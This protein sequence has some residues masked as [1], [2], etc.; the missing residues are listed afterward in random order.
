MNWL[1]SQLR[2]LAGKVVVPRL[3]ARLARFQQRLERAREV[4][5]ALWR[6]KVRRAASSGFGRDHGF[7]QVRDYADFKKAVPI[8][9]YDYYHPY[10]DRVARGD[11]GAMFPAGEP[12]LMFTL[13]SGTTDIPKLIPINPTWMDEYRRGW[14]IW[15]VRAFLDHPRL[16]YSKVTGIAGNWDMR[17][18]PSDKPCGM[19]SGLSAKMQPGLLQMMY[20]VPPE[21]F[22]IP[23]STAKYYTALRLAVAE[24]EVGL[25]LTATPATVVH[26]AQLGDQF[27]D[28]LIKDIAD[29]TLD[30]AMDIPA[31][32]RARLARRI[33][34]DPARA[35]ELA[36]IANRTGQLFPR[37]YWNIDLVACWIGGTVG[38]YARHIADYWGP[39]PTRDI[40]LLCSEGRFTVPLSDN[41]PAG[42]LEV[43]SHF[44]EF[45]SEEEM[46]RADPTILRC[47][48]LEVDRS[49][50][51]LLTT[52]SGLYRYDIGDVLR[53]VGYI[54]EAP[55]VEFLHKGSR[56][57][58]MEGE[59]LTEYHF[60]KAVTEVAARNRLLVSGFTAVPVRP[61]PGTERSEPYYVLIVEEQDIRGRE[62]ALRFLAGVDAWLREKNVMYD[63]KRADSYLAPPRLVRVPSGS[64]AR[65]DQ[66]EVARRGVGEDHYKH[67]CLVL[68]QAFLDQFPK[69]EEIIPPS[70]AGA[71]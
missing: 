53:C 58:D 57:S 55:I 24:R 13:S 4:Q 42:V 15:G 10:I 26:Y 38:S 71:A 54:G 41:E 67:P 8:A 20:P 35:R 32:L 11:V 52:S 45:V 43:D 12:I 22:S 14:Q 28:S 48:E 44:Y 29:G 1:I 59:K 9:Q 25:F 51:I 47:H 34:K 23:D 65:Y 66:Q 63:G 68:D 40:G 18:T 21:V 50:Y 49:Y 16:F 6:A 62:T 17:R 31:A 30:T 46:G 27:K 3:E 5:E 37:D 64:L 56:C 19:A 69:V 7:S 70:S 33:K 39:V 60:V 2:A 61:P 36:D